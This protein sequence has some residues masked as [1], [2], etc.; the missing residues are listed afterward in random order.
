MEPFFIDSKRAEKRLQSKKKMLKYKQRGE[1]LIFD[2]DGVAHPL[3][4]LKG[5]QQF[6]EHGLPEDQRRQFVEEEREKVAINDVEDK[7]LAKE[8]R[9]EK[10]N[11][12][13]ERERKDT[14]NKTAGSEFGGDVDNDALA[15][16][17]KLAEEVHSEDAD[18]QQQ[19][20]RPPK[21]PKKWFEEEAPKKGKRKSRKGDQAV[22]EVESFEDLE[23][24]ASG[25]LGA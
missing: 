24:L 2:D 25:L 3:Y 13:K 22:D 10:K 8:K 16:F 18:E 6:K 5:E 9:R 7:A 15:D 14:A 12:R 21:R 1:R 20:E 23:A 4:E 19:E 17:I 11:K